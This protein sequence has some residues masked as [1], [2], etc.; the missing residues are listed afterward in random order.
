[1][2]RPVEFV[3]SDVSELVTEDF[4]QEMAIRWVKEE[5]TQAH[6]AATRVSPT[7]RLTQPGAELDADEPLQGR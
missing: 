1:V 4:V 6:H 5:G 2:A 7:E 3:N